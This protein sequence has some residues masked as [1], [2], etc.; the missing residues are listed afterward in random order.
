MKVKN[1][2]TLQI[3]ERPGQTTAGLTSASQLVNITDAVSFDP[4]NT[5]SAI[6]EPIVSVPQLP[7]LQECE[8]PRDV[9]REALRRSM[10]RDGKILDLLAK[11]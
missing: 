1:L 9:F 3:E 4:S 7:N 6:P 5:S 8:T 11:F 10:R 2:K